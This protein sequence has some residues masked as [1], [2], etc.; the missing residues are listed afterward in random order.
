MLDTR[1]HPAA[2]AGRRLSARVLRRDA[3]AGDDRDG[4][5]LQPKLIIADEP[6]T[7]LDVTVQAQILRAARDAARRDRGGGHPDHPRP[8]RGRGGLRSGGGDV[9]RVGR[10]ARR[11]RRLVRPAE[12]RRT[13]RGLLGSIPRLDERGRRLPPITG[14]PPSLI[15]HLPADARSH[16]AAVY[17][18][19]HDDRCAIELPDALGSDGASGRGATSRRV[20][21]PGDLAHQTG[22]L[23][24]RMLEVPRPPQ[25]VRPRRTGAGGVVS[26]RR[27]RASTSTRARASAIVGESG[28]G[29]ST[30]GPGASSGWSSRRRRGRVRRAG[31]RRPRPSGD[32]AGPAA[33]C[34]W[35]SR[36]RTRRSN[37]RR[38]SA[39]PRRRRS[40]P[41]ASAATAAQAEVRAEMLERVGLTAS[42]STGIR[43]SSPAVSG[44]GS[45]SP[46]RSRSARS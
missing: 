11:R 5:E 33:T 12:A 39:D 10:R 41:A 28:C 9:C 27:R 35:C 38:R 43:T 36:I 19:V 44:S 29:K 40:D 18:R 6:T 24:R 3:A 16:R 25:D 32:A 13:R 21:T 23:Q 45:G 34:R 37:P 30:T 20:R 8:R 26:G 7:A 15:D 31:R 14:S 1:R 2:E 4:A 42:I 46:G 22:R 17:D